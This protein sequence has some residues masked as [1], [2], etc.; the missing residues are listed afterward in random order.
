[1]FGRVNSG[2]VCWLEREMVGGWCWAE[3]AARPPASTGA[4]GGWRRRTLAE[5]M[6]R[7][8]RCSGEDGEE[9]V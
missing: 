6:E 3:I 4:A 2:G 7:Q 8:G 5:G 1:M 9:P